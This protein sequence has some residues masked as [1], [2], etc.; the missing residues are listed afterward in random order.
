M[1]PFVFH[2]R[3]HPH[4]L[5]H[6]RH[7]RT[8]TQHARATN[9]ISHRLSPL[10]TPSHPLVDAVVSWRAV[11]VAEV[12]AHFY[13]RLVELHNY[14]SAN[15]LS[16]KM[17]NW[18]TL[19]GRVLKRLGTGAKSMKKIKFPCTRYHAFTSSP[20]PFGFHVSPPSHTRARMI[21]QVRRRLMSITPA[22]V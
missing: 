21:L 2:T 7:P 20:H 11:L 5:N 3:A 10:F 22:C 8:H 13:P 6:P 12:I 1:Y 4:P 16:Q 15:S 19:N 18:N 9:L 17:Y 14:S